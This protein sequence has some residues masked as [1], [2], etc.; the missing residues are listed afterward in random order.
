MDQICFFCFY[1]RFFMNRDRIIIR[2]SVIGI[3]ANVFLAAFK[4]AV[5]LLTNSIAIILDAVNNLT[6]VL[7]SLITIIGTRLSEKE[8]DREHP[9]GHG[10]IEYLAALV[11]ASSYSTPALMPCGTPLLCWPRWYSS[12]GCGTASARSGPPTG[13]RCCSW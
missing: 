2:T 3:L 8:A 7:S 6:D 11:T 4:A 12:S 5:G 9:F 13:R 1:R 10:R